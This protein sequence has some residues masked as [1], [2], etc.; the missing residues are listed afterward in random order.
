MGGC[1]DPAGTDECAS[2]R[3]FSLRLVRKRLA[4]MVK[5]YHSASFGVK[6]LLLGVGDL[7]HPGVHAGDRVIPANDAFR[8]GAK[9]SA[10]DLLRVQQLLQL[11]GT[12]VEA[13]VVFCTNG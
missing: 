4:K 3:V 10:A 1:D 11:V 2:A 13:H 5:N 9:T 8:R 7:R 6:L 12:G